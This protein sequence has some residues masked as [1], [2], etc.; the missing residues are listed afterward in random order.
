MNVW[1]VNPFDDL[2]HEAGRPMRYELLCRRLA[3]DGHGVTW[4]SS[5]FSHST[6]DYRSLPP[7]AAAGGVPAPAPPAIRLVHTPRYRRNIGLARLRNHRLFARN[8]ERDARDAV[9]SGELQK[10]DRILVSLPPLGTAGA[11]FRLRADWKCQVIVDIQDAWPETFLRLLPGPQAVRRPLGRLL[12]APFF[13]AAAAAYRQAD[14][15]SACAQGYLDLAAVHNTQGLRHLYYHGTDLSDRLPAREFPAQFTAQRP[16]RLVYAGAMGCTYGLASAIRAVCRLNQEGLPVEL[17]IAGRGGQESRLRKLSAALVPGRQQPC[18]QFHGYLTGE[19]F[20][21]FLRAGDAG[22]L[23]MHPDSLVGI[24]NKLVDYTAAGLPVLNCLPGETQALLARYQ[25][26]FAYRF[27]DESSLCES[28][29]GI[30]RAPAC[31]PAAAAGSARLA[32]DCF[33]AARNFRDFARFIAEK[34]G[35]CRRDHQKTARNWA[36]RLTECIILRAFRG[37][38]WLWLF[39]ACHKRHQLKHHAQPQMANLFS[40]DATIPPPIR[41]NLKHKTT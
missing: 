7:A 2:P 15:V 8:W 17:H 14:K 39:P 22:L 26:G 20:H 34:I 21:T 30:L 9:G 29:A 33:D 5:D 36:S 1:I 4:W 31:L 27:N 38:L 24:P 6:K 35:R 11:A 40:M 25:A 16:L 13:R 37:G 12:L 32:R 10:P 23:P 3:A 19:P 18:V 41:I 28:L